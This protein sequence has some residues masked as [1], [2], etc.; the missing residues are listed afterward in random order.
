MNSK[1]KKLHNLYYNSK[2]PTAFTGKENLWRKAKQSIPNLNKVEFETWLQNQSAYTLHKQVRRKFKRTKIVACAIDEQ[3]QADLVDM[4]EFEKEN[5]GIKYLLTIIDVLSRYAMVSPLNNKSGLGVSKA[6]EK[7]FQERKPVYLQTDKK[8]EF[9][10]DSMK[11]LLNK[12]NIRHFS[13]ENSDI[14]C[15]IVERFNRT[16]KGRM[17]RYFTHSNTR[18]YIDVLQDF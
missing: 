12:L 10:N 16:L 17:F 3:W 11:Q 4:K 8:K 14:K 15:A 7:L 13:T 18:R 5:D 6:F 1:L 2:L 9:Y